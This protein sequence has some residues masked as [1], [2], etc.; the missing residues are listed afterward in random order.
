MFVVELT[1]TVDIATIDKFLVEH[2]LWLDT[3]YQANHFLCSGPQ[4]PRSGGIIIALTK[5]KDELQQILAN[6]PFSINKVA[7]YRIIEFDPI[8]HHAA[9]AK[10]IG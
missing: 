10:L 7:D 1:Y 4:N 5:S 9:I 2:R 3:M 8:K 6:D